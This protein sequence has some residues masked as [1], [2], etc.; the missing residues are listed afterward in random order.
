[1]LREISGPVGRLE[2]LLD[3]PDASWKASSLHAAVVLAHPLT[4]HGGTMHTK[5]V[6]QAAKALTR[7][8]CAVL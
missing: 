7:I 8:G 5:A 4:T 1:M 2:A 6:Y 3:E